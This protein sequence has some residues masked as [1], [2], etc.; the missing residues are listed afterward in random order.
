[1][2]RIRY[3]VVVDNVGRLASAEPLRAVTAIQHDV[4]ELFKRLDDKE[5]LQLAGLSDFDRMMALEEILSR[6]YGPVES[7]R[8]MRAV[9]KFRKRFPALKIPEKVTSSEKSA[10]ISM[11]KK[12]HVIGLS[13]DE[14]DLVAASV[15]ASAPWLREASTLAMRGLRMTADTGVQVPLM[16]L[17]GPPGTGKTTWAA[18][19]ARGLGV[20]VLRVSATSRGVFALAGLEGGWSNA[21]SGVLV[22]EILRTGCGNPI[23]I[24]DEI[25]KAPARVTTTRSG[26]MPSIVDTILDMSE[27]ATARDWTCPHLGVRFDLSRVSWVMTA[28][29][30]DQIP[31]PL[32]DRFRVIQVLPPTLDEMVE[33][34]YLRASERLGEDAAAL[35]V[36]ALV[37]ADRRGLKPS[38]RTI[39]RMIESAEGVL[40]TPLLN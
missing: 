25:D 31:A 13:A 15:H 37:S 14:I 12:G 26:E 8:V 40:E 18:D 32:R 4:G 27:P 5:E 6:R 35:I 23:V 39:E 28:N 17:A 30:A 9:Q 10:V 11:A 21:H 36:D 33:L 20:P 38:L 16:I 1:M 24:V 29:D 7:G 22:S 34:G 2:H 3:R 19:L